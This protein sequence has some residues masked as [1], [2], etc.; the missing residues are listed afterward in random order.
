[1]N[2]VLIINENDLIYKDEVLGPNTFVWSIR[3]SSNP[4]CKYLDMGFVEQIKVGKDPKTKLKIWKI[5]VR[6][7]YDNK[8]VYDRLDK[9]NEKYFLEGSKAIIEAAK[10]PRCIIIH[11]NRKYGFIGEE[12]V[13]VKDIKQL[14]DEVIY[15]ILHEDGSKETINNNAIISRLLEYF[16]INQVS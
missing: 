3:E 1:M 4:K 15:E 6:S 2:D 13:L 5:G 9:I 8:L 12:T 16:K 10:D 14:R 11:Y 7:N